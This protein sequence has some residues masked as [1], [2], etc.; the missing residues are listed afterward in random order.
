[1]LVATADEWI[2][3]RKLKVGDKHVNA[4]EVLS[5]GDHLGYSV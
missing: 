4:A 3:V 1:M 2:V 5:T